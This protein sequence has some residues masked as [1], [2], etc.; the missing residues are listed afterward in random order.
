VQEIFDQA[1]KANSLETIMPGRFR[2]EENTGRAT[3]VAKVSDDKKSMFQVFT[4]EP[5][6]GAD[7]ELV[8]V[9]AEQ[10]RV[11]GYAGGDGRFLI[12]NDGYRYMGKPGE[13]ELQV[14]DFVEYG[15]RLKDIN[16]AVRKHKKTDAR[17]MQEL[18]KS[19]HLEDK[20]TFQ[21]RVSLAILVPIIALIAQALSKTN[22]RRGRYVKMLP[23]FLVYIIYLVMLNA[24]RDAI[25]KGDLPLAVGMWWVHGLFLL[26]ALLLLFGG[27]WLR[28]LKHRGVQA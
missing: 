25:E 15:Q 13:A 18:M 20:A 16:P 23:A 5:R 9:V 12:L 3:Y 19:K 4:A 17:T 1:K 8:V 24:A 26:L 10:G 28:W 27:D 6:K 7:N 14:T 22:H 21:W 11:G 2:V